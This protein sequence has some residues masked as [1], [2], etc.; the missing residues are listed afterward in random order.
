MCPPVFPSPQVCYCHHPGG[1]ILD[2][3]LV[4]YMQF[5]VE[6]GPPLQIA[7]GAVP[8]SHRI[9]TQLGPGCPP[10]SGVYGFM[11]AAG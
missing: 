11:P 10:D 1:H 7:V 5:A 8:R 6:E 3:T 4:C 9:D 2:Q